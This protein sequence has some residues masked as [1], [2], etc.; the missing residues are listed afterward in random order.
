[1][2]FYTAYTQKVTPESIAEITDMMIQD[3]IMRGFMMV[4][5]TLVTAL[6]SLTLL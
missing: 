1:M 2:N 5:G 3:L 6:S 4:S